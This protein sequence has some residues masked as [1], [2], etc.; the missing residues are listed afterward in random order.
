MTE[1]LF[2]ALNYDI[3]PVVFGGSHYRSFMPKHSFIDANQFTPKHLAQHLIEIA[4]NEQKY[5]SYF[6]WKQE[7]SVESGFDSE[8]KVFCKLC[9]ILNSHKTYSS[10][11]SD[12]IIEWWFR[13]A[14]C[15]TWTNKH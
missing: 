14:N 2:E 13:K 11:S 15:K 3:V 4:S 5:L 10:H 1:K 9:Q 8:F 6:K 7:Y 12:Q